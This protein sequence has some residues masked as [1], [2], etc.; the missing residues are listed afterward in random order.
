MTPAEI[1]ATLQR[2]RF[3][4]ATEDELQRGIALALVAPLGGETWKREVRLTPQ[5]RPDFFLES[6]GIVIEVKIKGSFGNTLRQLDRYASLP[7]VKGI[8]LVTTRSVQALRMPYML[9]GK[10]LAVCCLHA[11]C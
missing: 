9:Q 4:C 8:V 5:D 10:P 11:L 2:Y 7:A 3:S 1:V 6:Y